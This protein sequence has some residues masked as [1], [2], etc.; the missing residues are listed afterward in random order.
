MLET[1]ICLPIK[2]RPTVSIHIPITF[3]AMGNLLDGR[4]GYLDIIALKNGLK[5]IIDVE[6]M[7]LDYQRPY[8]K[9]RLTIWAV[10][11]RLVV[12]DVFEETVGVIGGESCRAVKQAMAKIGLPCWTKQGQVTHLSSR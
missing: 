12:K 5:K 11:S 8:E 10:G 6:F 7:G 2:G 3:M 9:K 4:Y 1:K